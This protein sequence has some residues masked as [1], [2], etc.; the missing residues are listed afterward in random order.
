MRYAITLSLFL[1]ACGHFI[2]TPI[3]S[4]DPAL[5]EYVDEFVAESNHQGRHV[6]ITDLSVH[7]TPKLT[8]THLASC[9]NYHGDD[10]NIILVDASKW[11][12]ESPE[13]RKAMMFHELGHC[14]LN[15]PHLL[16][17]SIRNGRWIV[18]SIMFPDI[19]SD[20]SMYVDNWDYYMVE[21]FTGVSN[22][23]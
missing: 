5:Q 19:Q 16:T 15:R 10:T 21:L 13:Y 8:G 3:V 2:H 18:D 23:F 1:C 22:G 9:D 20:T 12:W 4:I 11:E 7:F 14:V 17:W 6:R